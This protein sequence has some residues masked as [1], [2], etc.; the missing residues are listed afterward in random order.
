MKKKFIAAVVLAA[1]FSGFL[2]TGVANASTALGGHYSTNP[3]NGFGKNKTITIDGSFDDWSEDMMIAKGVANDDPRI[4]RGSHE[5]PV[6]DTY[7]LY[8]AWDDENLY[9]MWQYTNVTDVTDPGQTYPVSDNGKPYNGDIPI[10]I[11]LNTGKQNTTNGTTTDGKGVWGLKVNFSTP[12][13]T[14]LCFSAKPGVGQP[15]LFTATSDGTLDYTTCVGF[16]KAGITYK[17]GDGFLGSIIEGI[18]AN[19]YGG[20]TP[21]DLLKDSSNW[22]NFLNEGHNTNQDTMYE[23]KIPLSALGID[24]NYLE[25]NGIGAMLISTFGES[26]IASLPMDMTFL[27]SATEP[28]TADNSTSAEKE[29][30]DDV[31]VPLAKIGALSE[32]PIIIPEK[33]VMNLTGISTNLNSPQ[34]A[35]TTIKL[36]AE[37]TFKGDLSYKYFVYD[38]NGEWTAISDYTSSKSVDWTPNKEGKYI[39]WVDVKDKDNNVKS[40]MIDYDV[41]K[42][43]N[44]NYIQEDDSRIVYLGA[45]T[46]ESS[47]LY[48]GG[49]AML[50]DS[51][52]AKATLSFY[53]TGVKLLST[54]GNDKGIAKVTVDDKVYSADMCRTNVM[55][56]AVAFEK[57]GLGEGNHVITIECS[58]LS[59][60]ESKGTAISIDSIGIIK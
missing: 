26:G 4:F 21:D 55:N 45:W 18:K 10:M 30:A 36:T 50:T 17:Y 1:A 54:L 56:N 47:S 24:K 23:M 38:E 43:E 19:G 39:I 6:Y 33:P 25:T 9:L 2:G 48:A 16:D 58:G 20:Y 42:P 60:R 53:G 37:G 7:A 28:Y 27:D 40:Y 52:G 49:K 14:V 51:I 3:S 35:G 44:C 15:A 46:S 41:T 12:V 34:E 59:S 57:T 31:T 32:N 5:G 11:A 8:S 22:V 29:D 13:D